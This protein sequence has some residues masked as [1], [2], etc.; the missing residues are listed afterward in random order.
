MRRNICKATINFPF[1]LASL[2]KDAVPP[3]DAMI[4][5]IVALAL[6]VITA[7]SLAPLPSRNVMLLSRSPC[8]TA[9]IVDNSSKEVKR[10][11]F[12][13]GGGD[14]SSSKRVDWQDMAESNLMRQGTG[15]VASTATMMENFKRSQQLGKKTAS[16][17]EELSAATVIGW[18]VS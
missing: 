7:D 6:A 8:R 3:H 13:F 18:V 17:M 15:E 2:L 16:L 14:K 12:G 9:D 1:C 5:V 11:L 4:F 10:Y